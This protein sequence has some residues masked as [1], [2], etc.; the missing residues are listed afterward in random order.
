MYYGKGNPGDTNAQVFGGLFGRAQW[1]QDR[2]AWMRTQYAK[3][4]KT[5]ETTIY[6]AAP[7]WGA[8]NELSGFR[9]DRQVSL[10]AAVSTL[11]AQ[12]RFLKPFHAA[13]AADFLNLHL[14]N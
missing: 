9:Y 13:F 6:E 4:V 8:W 10:G 12:R 11:D 1:F 7:V 5:I 3:Y 2:I 14:P